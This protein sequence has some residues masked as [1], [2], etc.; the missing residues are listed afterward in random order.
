MAKS[1]KRPR[2][3]WPSPTPGKLWLH[4]KLK[5]LPFSHIG[6]FA[7]GRGNT[8]VTFAPDNTHVHITRDL[9]KTWTSRPMYEYGP[10]SKEYKFSNERVLLRTAQGTLIASF[11]NMNETIWR[12]DS[13]QHDAAN[14][15]R[16]PQYVIRSTDGGE[17][18]EPPVL[19]HHHWTGDIRN[20]IQLASGRLVISSMHLRH[21][22]GRHTV[23][24]YASDDDGKTWTQGSVI[25]LGGMGHHGGVMEATIEQLRD[26]RVLML[27]RTNWG[28]FWRCLSDDGLHF[29]DIQPSDIPASSSPGL[30]KR[31]RSGRLMLLWNR[32]HPEGETSFPLVGGDGE[33]S[34]TPASY[35][36]EELSLAWYDEST[37]KVSEP[38]V[39]ARRRG[40]WLSYPRVFEVK[41]GELWLTTM[42]GGVCVALSEHDFV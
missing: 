14:D 33:W 35:H 15:V 18:W 19:L 9:G 32:M 29:R 7:R 4:P 8:I 16:G 36:R 12:W 20:A 30:L 37:H 17:S 23:V 22:P 24:T 31:L 1:T 2:N 41:P 27:M 28:R 21:K 38:V 5:T 25:D 3:G 42:Q 34:E 10:Q 13:Q 11:I 39:I 6:P 40:S 26:G